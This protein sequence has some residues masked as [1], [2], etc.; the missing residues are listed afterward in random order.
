MV[1]A[2]LSAPACAPRAAGGGEVPAPEE[3][4]VISRLREAGQTRLGEP[5]AVAVNFDGRAFVA[6][7]SPARLV[8]LRI[9]DGLAQEFQSPPAAG[10]YPSDVAVHG[11]F[12]YAID[13]TNRA[14]LRF[15]ERGAFRDVLVNFEELTVNR[16]I[17]P[18]GLAVDEI[19]RVAVT[20]IENHQVLLINNYLQLDLA[21]GNYGSYEG[22]LDTPRGVSFS[23]RE[24][25]LV[26]DTGNARV[27][28]FSD[29]GAFLR[30]FPPEGEAS[31]LVAPRRAIES[32]KG[33]VYVADPG[34]GA[35]IIFTPSGTLVGSFVPVDG[36]RF[37]P[38]DVAVVKGRVLVTDAA[39]QSLV[40]FEEF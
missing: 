28:Y 14:L 5:V 39:S 10:F 6:D 24:E 3:R 32:K 17:S 35:V 15:D 12:I 11:F 37:E 22:Q 26:A 16:R 21:F 23:P 4:R 20:D 30:A 40:V 27:Q 13:V 25:L 29:T 31:G 18:L 33:R 2:G 8:G 19:G 38:T 7:V 1:V 36:E 34:A 9:G